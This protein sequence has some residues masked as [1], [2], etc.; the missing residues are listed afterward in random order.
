MHG[1]PDGI[2]VAQDKIQW[3]VFMNMVMSIRS[4]TEEDLLAT[5]VITKFQWKNPYLTLPYL[6]FISSLD[7]DFL[8]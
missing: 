3:R 4:N 2:Q 5:W 1:D 8:L 6:N 7:P